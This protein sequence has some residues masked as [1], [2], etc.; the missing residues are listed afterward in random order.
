MSCPRSGSTLRQ[1][2]GV[3]IMDINYV[4]RAVT[5]HFKDGT[6]VEGWYYGQLPLGLLISMDQ[7]GHDVRLF[8]Q[9]W[10]GRQFKSTPG[11]KFSVSDEARKQMKAL[12][13]S[14]RAQTETALQR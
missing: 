10:S 8:T 11:A 1:S 12:D 14:I 2:F 5:L 4:G 3:D 6:T 7:E 13:D 9:E